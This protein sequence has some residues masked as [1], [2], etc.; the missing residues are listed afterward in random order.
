VK[1]AISIPDDLAREV[2]RFVR[3]H[4]LS[5]SEFY[6]RAA[7]ALL[8]PL[9]DEDVTRSYSEADE[10]DGGR[11]PDSAQRRVNRELLAVEWDDS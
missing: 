1:T 5:R 10:N 3:K 11:L 9:R 4:G 2:E 7:K 8:Q 6:A